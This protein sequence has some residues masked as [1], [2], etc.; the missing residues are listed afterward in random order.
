[1][2]SPV[3]L[4]LFLSLCLSLSSVKENVV[5]YDKAHKSNVSTVDCG[6]DCSMDFREVLYFSL[7]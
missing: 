6:L 3:S 5:I 4:H 1:M 2:R 7:F